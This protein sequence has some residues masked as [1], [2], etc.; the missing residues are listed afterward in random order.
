MLILNNK[1]ITNLAT[2]TGIVAALLLALN[3]NQFILAYILFLISA[4]LW[5]IFAVRDGNKQL[6]IM[7]IVFAI[8]NTIGLIR[9]S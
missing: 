9:F 7:N 6:L 8:I 5:T 3:I 4:I 1:I 2:S